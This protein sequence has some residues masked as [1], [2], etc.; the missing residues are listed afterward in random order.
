MFDDPL[1][2]AAEAAG[3]EPA[4]VTIHSFTPYWRGVPRPW[5]VGI[6]YDRD[7]RLARPLIAALEA[8]PAKLIVGDKTHFAPIPAQATPVAADV[9][10]RKAA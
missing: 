10:D 1:G 5:H 2:Q 9:T 4:L 8:D 7:E 6:L 3:R